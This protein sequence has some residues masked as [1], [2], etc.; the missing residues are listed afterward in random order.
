[1]AARGDRSA[2]RHWTGRPRAA[3]TLPHDR[4]RS[5][6]ADRKS[7]AR[8]SGRSRGRRGPNHR[9]CRHRGQ[10]EE[11]LEHDRAGR[12]RGRGQGRRLWLR[13]RAG[14]RQAGEGRLPDLL[15]CRRRRGAPRARDHAR[16][17]HLCAQRGHAGHG[18]IF[19]RRRVAAGHQQHDRARRVGCIRLHQDLARRR[20][21]ARRHRHQPPRHHARRGGRYCAA[22]PVRASRLHAVDEPTRLRRNSRPCDE[23]PADPDIPRNPHHVSR[24]SVLAGQLIGDISRRHRLL[25]SGAARRRAVRGQSHRRTPEPHAPGG[26]AQ[27]PHRPGA[28]HQ[29]RRDR[30]LRRDLDRRAAEPARDRRGRLRGRLFAVRRRRQA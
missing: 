1:M 13:P 28:Q 19:R 14:H 15:R 26:R 6:L 25:R 9:P 7:A 10:L 23:R 2:T 20:G 17:R 18:A 12:M 11:A 30:R 22:H 21:A 29:A 8:R 24:R 5:R 16:Q 3:I 27:S 4:P